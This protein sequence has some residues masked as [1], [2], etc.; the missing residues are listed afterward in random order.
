MV[1]N[2]FWT[3]PLWLM[4]RLM[5]AMKL[6]EFSLMVTGVTIIFFAESPA[7]SDLHINYKEVLAVIFTAEHWA[8]PLW[9]CKHVIIHSDSQAAVG[10]IN[11]GSTKNPLIMGFLRGLFW[12]SAIYNF[13]I[14]TCY[15]KGVHN[16]IADAI[17][18]M[19]MPI[20]SYLLQAYSFIS[21]C[22]HHI[23]ALSQNLLLHMPYSTALFLSF[24]YSSSHFSKGTQC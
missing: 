16:V 4:Y 13:R 9:S 17:S 19:L 1:G 11:K 21:T 12:L 3:Q 10:I 14:T 20:A 15:I 18:R 6:L 22:T 2:Y 8:P 7:M 5:L 24:R 23:A